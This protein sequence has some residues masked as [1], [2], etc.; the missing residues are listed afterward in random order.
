M[1]DLMLPLRELSPGYRRNSGI[2]CAVNNLL[3]VFHAGAR[4]KEA[5]PRRSTVI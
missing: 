5:A 2:E 1:L 3:C 4:A